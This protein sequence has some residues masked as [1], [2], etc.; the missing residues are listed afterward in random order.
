MPYK[1]RLE[2]GEE[3]LIETAEEFDTAA[4]KVRTYMEPIVSAQVVVPAE[5][6]G[7]MMTLLE[8]KR[9]TNDDLEFLD[10]DT[11]MLKYVRG[12]V[13][14]LNSKPTFV[15]SSFDPS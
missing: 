7:T 13:I 14:C 9:G 15:A 4:A 10:E 2:S 11:V 5:Y 3:I 1:A 8:G 12:I 6:L